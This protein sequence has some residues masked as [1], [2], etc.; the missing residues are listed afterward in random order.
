[1]EQGSRLDSRPASSTQEAPHHTVDN[2]VVD[3]A[4]ARLLAEPSG[5][6]D[7]A[8][9]PPI[10]LTPAEACPA[11][12]TGAQIGRLTAHH[13]DLDVSREP[14]A[15]K[16]E[17]NR[18][19]DRTQ[20]KL[21]LLA[22]A[23]TFHIATS[24]SGAL[25]QIVTG[26]QFMRQPME[27][28][29]LSPDEIRALLEKTQRC[30]FS[31]AGVLAAQTGMS[32]RLFGSDYTLPTHL[33]HLR[34]AYAPVG[35]RQSIGPKPTV[36][37]TQASIPFLEAEMLRLNESSDQWWKLYDQAGD[38]HNEAE[39]ASRSGNR[40][41]L[42]KVKMAD[43]SSGHATRI[44]R[45]NLLSTIALPASSIRELGLQARLISGELSEWWDGSD[46]PPGEL[47]ARTLLDRIMGLA[48]VVRIYRRDLQPKEVEGW[49]EDPLA[50]PGYFPEFREGR[51]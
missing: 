11:F 29:D 10:T 48:G 22:E 20:S 49:I 16:G 23:M 34:L 33:D 18:E 38:L 5:V 24:V 3:E 13:Y 19:M 37:A 30:L 45:E 1:M 15:E 7:G 51:A 14:E 31:V 40:D 21:D 35:W 46:L 6:S 50:Y 17:R 12:Q 25:A 8:E 44:L 41:A 4:V 42:K 9:L 39:Y 43:M 28:G 26:I 2:P 27:H 32:P 36:P 47:A